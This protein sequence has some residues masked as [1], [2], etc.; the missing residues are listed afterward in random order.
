MRS[1]QSSGRKKIKNI[2][3]KYS[4]IFIQRLYDAGRRSDTAVPTKAR[5]FGRRR[6]VN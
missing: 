5:N 6:G 3:G 4:S 1:V 2:G